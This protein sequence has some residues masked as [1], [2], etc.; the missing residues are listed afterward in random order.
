MTLKS[1]A[2]GLVIAASL[3]FAS[4]ANASIALTFVGASAQ[5]DTQLI[6]RPI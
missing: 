5:A 3:G 6:G 2:A 4:T 1:T